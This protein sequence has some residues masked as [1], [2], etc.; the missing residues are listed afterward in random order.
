MTPLTHPIA[1]PALLALLLIAPASPVRAAADPP[2]PAAALASAAGVSFAEVADLREIDQR[3][4]DGNFF[5]QVSLNTVR[6][7]GTVLDTID[8]VKDYGGLRAPGSPA[9][10]PDPTGRKTGG[11][12]FRVDESTPV[13]IRDGE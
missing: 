2:D 6:K 7:S 13:K 4:S 1:L 11:E 12:V 3:P 8:I 10:G 9:P 5:I